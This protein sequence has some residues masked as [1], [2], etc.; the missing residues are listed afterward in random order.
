MRTEKS[1]RAFQMAVKNPK[2]ARIL[3]DEVEDPRWM[4]H[5]AFMFKGDRP[6]MRDRIA[7]ADDVWV[8]EW[9]RAFPEDRPLFHD[10]L[11]KGG[12]RRIYRNYL[13]SMC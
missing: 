6:V 7:G 12:M 2:L 3:R 5:W 13:R 9:V 10:R 11:I 1:F 4:L 8:F